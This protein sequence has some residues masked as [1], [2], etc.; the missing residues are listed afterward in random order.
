MAPREDVDGQEARRRIGTDGALRPVDEGP[1]SRE[2]E[3]VNQKRTARRLDRHAPRE[4]P[5]VRDS[6]AHRAG[7]GRDRR[8][9]QVRNGRRGTPLDHLPP[10]RGRHRSRDEPDVEEG[11]VAHPGVRR[12]TRGVVNGPRVRVGR[13]GSRRGR[14]AGW[15]RVERR[16]EPSPPRNGR[17]GG[18]SREGERSTARNES[19]ERG[20]RECQDG[21]E[22]PRELE[23]REDGERVPGGARGRK[24]SKERREGHGAPE[25][26][27]RVG[28]APESPSHE[29]R[30]EERRE[31]DDGPRDPPPELR[32]QLGGAEE[33]VLRGTE[34]RRDAGVEELGHTPAARQGRRDEGE[35]R[36][37]GTEERAGDGRG[38]A[39]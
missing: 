8:G 21:R 29:R 3:L 9:P 35:S 18:R 20:K 34:E 16:G 31:R 36:E 28:S 15:E 6:P 11:G 4:T 39:P 27:P 25:S 22:P 24:E 5:P 32:V 17:H 23:P 10:E 14:R 12:E 7:A 37:A 30:H 2:P 13:A 38:P 26:P 19:H 1:E 33:D